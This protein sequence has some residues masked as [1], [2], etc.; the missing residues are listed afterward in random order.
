M[1]KNIQKSLPFSEHLVL[2]SASPRRRELLDGMGLKFDVVPTNVEDDSIEGKKLHVSELL[3]AKAVLSTAEK[4]A[5]AV[6][7]DGVTVIAADTAV[8]RFGKLYGK[9]LTDAN[10]MIMLSELQGKWHAV[11]TGVVVRSGD[12]ERRFV[13]RSYVKFKKLDHVD[14]ASYVQKCH[15]VDKA[16]AYGIQDKQIVQKYRGSYSNIVGLPC[17]KLSR[18][19]AEVGVLNDNI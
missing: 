17:E 4:K 3:P 9:P 7:A 2:A 10:A 13:V 15:P 5:R 12:A 18:V 6:A 14:I 8:V 19:L 16:G 1:S 11:Y